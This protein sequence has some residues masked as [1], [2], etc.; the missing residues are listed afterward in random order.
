MNFLHPYQCTNYFCLLAYDLEVFLSQTVV[1]LSRI[2]LPDL[3]AFAIDSSSGCRPRIIPFIQFP[4]PNNASLKCDELLRGYVGLLPLHYLEKEN[5]Y[6]LHK[7][8]TLTTYYCGEPFLNI[9]CAVICC[10]TDHFWF[11]L[12]FYPTISWEQ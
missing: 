11:L 3:S 4:S 9:N 10:F 1:T 8:T 12:Y 7:T 5:K 2:Q 6:S